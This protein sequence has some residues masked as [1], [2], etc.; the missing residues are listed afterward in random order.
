M[1]AQCCVSEPKLTVT[2]VVESEAAPAPLSVQF[3]LL[4]QE[5]AVYVVSASVAAS[6][7]E[8]QCREFMKLVLEVKTSVLQVWQ[9][10]QKVEI[11]FLK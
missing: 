7:L 8:A 10:K 11:H 3:T 6:S 5:A 2:A 9:R 1:G 4:Q